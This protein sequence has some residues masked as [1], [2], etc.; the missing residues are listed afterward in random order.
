M[1]GIRDSGRRERHAALQ[2]Q[3]EHLSKKAKRVKFE[4]ERE[5][6][7]REERGSNKKKGRGGG[8]NTRQKILKNKGEK[9]LSLGKN[10]IK[11]NATKPNRNTKS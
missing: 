4:L 7:G 6:P 8:S 9:K 10:Q 3:V 11:P 2:D 1:A 5:T